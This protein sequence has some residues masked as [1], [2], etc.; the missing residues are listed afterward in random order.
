MFSCPAKTHS[1]G[2]AIR[3]TSKGSRVVDART[4]A[5][6][7]GAKMEEQQKASGAKD[8]WVKDGLW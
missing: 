6:V 8:L 3:I 5:E 7:I 4:A 2:K 1:Y